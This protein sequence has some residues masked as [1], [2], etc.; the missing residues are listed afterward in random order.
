MDKVSW[1][2]VFNGQK[3]TCIINVSQHDLQYS[4]LEAIMGMDACVVG[5]YYEEA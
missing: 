1:D 2:S 3:D 4:Y 5:G